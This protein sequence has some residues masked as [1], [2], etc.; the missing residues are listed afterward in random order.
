MNPEQIVW[1]KQ[2]DYHPKTKIDLGLAPPVIQVDP[3]TIRQELRRP[4]AAGDV[5]NHSTIFLRFRWN[6]LSILISLAAHCKYCK[7]WMECYDPHHYGFKRV[8]K[9]FAQTGWLCYIGAL[10]ELG[11]AKALNKFQGQITSVPIAIAQRCYHSKPW[12]P[13]FPQLNFMIDEFQQKDVNLVLA[14]LGLKI[15]D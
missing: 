10:Q 14:L 6:L 2:H 11:F 1:H 15:K 12:T 7:Y 4:L 9:H 3:Y 13:L 8:S 5:R